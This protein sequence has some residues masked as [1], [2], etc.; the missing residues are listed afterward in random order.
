MDGENTRNPGLI[1]V[2][3]MP[4]SQNVVAPF[5]SSTPELN[6]TFDVPER[7]TSLFHEDTAHFRELHM[8]FIVASEQM[9]SMLFFDLSDLFTECR[10]GDVQSV[11]G[12]REVQLFG[13]DNDCMQVPDFEV[14]E[15]CSKTPGG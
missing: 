11:G 7:G 10:L 8:P 5:A 4:D 15:H 9:K 1:G 3:R 13:Q 14:G 12:L 2:G 6:G